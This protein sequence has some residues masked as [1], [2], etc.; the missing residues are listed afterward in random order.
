MSLGIFIQVRLGSTRLPGKA[1]LPLPGGSVIQHV[2]RAMAAVPA[3][4]RAL[5]TE[6][7]S[8]TQLAP[9]ARQEGFLLF[10]GP[11]DDVLAR[12]CMACREYRVDTAIRVTGDNPLTSA[13]LAK[14]ILAKHRES[15][16][17]LSHY[18]ASLGEVES[19]SS[20]RNP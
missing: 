19:K 11:D 12:Y 8:A 10:V 18:V 13:Q 17:D 6:Q 2:M 20:D 7:R 1:L 3:D 15:A 4:V 5:V 9:V 14:S 16:S